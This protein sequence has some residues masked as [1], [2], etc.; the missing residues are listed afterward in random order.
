RSNAAF[1]GQAGTNGFRIIGGTEADTC[2]FPW[3]VLIY[4]QLKSSICG[5]SII[6]STHIATAAH[7]LFSRNERTN[8][9][10][11]SRANELLVFS[12][13]ST[14]PLSGTDV[15]GLVRRVVTEVITHQSYNHTSLE[16]DMAILKLSQPIVYDQCHK[17]ICM[18]DGSKAPDQASKCRTMGWG[19][20][21]NGADAQASSQLQYVDV[22]IVSNDSCRAV[23]G[24]LS[25]S[26]T[27]CAGSEG[28]DSC[29]GDSGGPFTCQ[30]DDG[31]NYL[32]GIVSA[33]IEGRCGSLVG[34]YSKVAA[35]IDWINSKLQ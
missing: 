29:Q 8:I 14:M 15:D 31:K 28:R 16:N 2:E 22:T 6:D 21:S 18:V 33:G 20:T 19:L 23:Y 30:G 17:P 25:S 35:F 3:M 1:C 11:K 4:D 10:R 24:S 13:S 7:C 5:G 34:I 26:K 9:V 12:G 27:F 32:Y